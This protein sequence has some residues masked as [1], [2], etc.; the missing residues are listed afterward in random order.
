[1]PKARPTS[2]QIERAARDLAER[3]ISQDRRAI[4]RAITHV[5]NGSPVG[6]ALLSVIY[7]KT[8]GA[9]RIGIT[10]PPGAGKSTLVQSLAARL[11]ARGAPVGILAV[12]PT[13]PFTGGAILGDRI[14]VPAATGDP[15]LFMRSMAARGSLGGV[16]ATT[17]EVSEVLEAA[18]FEWIL[19]ETVGVGQ[20]EL[21]VVELADTTVLTLVPE[22][23][24]AVQTMK[25]GIMEVADILVVNKFDR[26]GGD[27]LLRDLEATLHLAGELKTLDWQP[28]ICATIAARDEGTAE[29]LEQIDAHGAWLTGEPERL[30]RIRAEK[31]RARLRALLKRALIESVWSEAQIEEQLGGVIG[32]I[33]ARTLSPYDWV[34]DILRAT[35]AR[36]EESCNG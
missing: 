9:H 34:A 29:L 36:R 31:I 19:I 22:S 18:G 25:A 33:A 35:L 14:R 20:S 7:K 8:G 3:L 32:Q 16:A 28:P 5:E 13:S 21:D 10:G 23:G 12:D 6:R 26:E 2:A 15:G 30:P 1:M 4:A 27:R 17:Y 11:R 24:D